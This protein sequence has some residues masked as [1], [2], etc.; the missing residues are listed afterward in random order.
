MHMSEMRQEAYTI[1]IGR[2]TEYARAKRL[3]NIGKHPTFIGRDMLYRSALNGGLFFFQKD[4]KD[5]AVAMI[6]PR[7]NILTVMNVLPEMRAKGLG[8]FIVNF[9]KPNWV[10][11]IDSAKEFFEKN[12]YVSIG[13]PKQGR[14]FLT[15]I[16]V[17]KNLLNLSTRINRLYEN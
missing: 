2:V 5:V 17:R 9:L 7:L 8:K 10:R 6:N 15:Q 11:A 4:G 13:E 12:G 14:R 1:V 16:M 3:L